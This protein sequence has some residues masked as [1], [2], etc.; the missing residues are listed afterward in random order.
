MGWYSRRIVLSGKWLDDAN[1]KGDAK[2]A[3]KIAFEIGSLIT[4]A[5]LVW[6]YNKDVVRSLANGEVRE[7]VNRQNRKASHS[8]RKSIVDRIRAE[9]SCGASEAFQ[10][11]ALRHPD[12]GTSATF[13]TSYY[14]KD[15]DS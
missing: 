12:K 4:E 6:A 5:Q 7:T 14:K 8:E 10:I 13:K 9:R 1:E 2:L 15:V 11:A 3:Q